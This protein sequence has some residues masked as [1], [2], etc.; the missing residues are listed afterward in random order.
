M[1][2]AS[3]LPLFR[4][5]FI[6]RIVFQSSYT[7]LIPCSALLHPIVTAE[8]GKTDKHHGIRVKSERVWA[9]YDKRDHEVGSSDYWD[10][11]ADRMNYNDQDVAQ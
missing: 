10:E 6:S 5:L 2:F 1:A 7:A 3:N 4:V 11:K 9:E 8:S